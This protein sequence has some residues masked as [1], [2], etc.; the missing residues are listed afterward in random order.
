MKHE[1]AEVQRAN[2]RI[3]D[4]L[5]NLL[6]I[7]QEIVKSPFDLP[8][9]LSR[10]VFA[11]QQALDSDFALLLPYDSQSRSFRVDLFTASGLSDEILK[12]KEKPRSGGVAAQVMS[13][14]TGILVVEDVSDRKRY[15]YVSLEPTSLVPKSG[16]KCFIGARMDAGSEVTGILF[17]DYRKPHTFVAVELTLVRLLANHAAI[18]IQNARLFDRISKSLEEKVKELEELQSRQLAAERLN[19]LAEIA[20]NFAHRIGNDIGTIPVCVQETRQALMVE[21]CD[22]RTADYYLSR[23]EYDAKNFLHTAELLRMPFIDSEVGEVDI[24]RAI[25]E[26]VSQ[27]IVPRDIVVNF[28]LAESLPTIRC[29]LVQFVNVLK[30]LIEN[31]FE[32]MP[33]GGSL[34]IHTRV[35]QLELGSRQVMLEFADT[36]QG[37]P[38]SQ[39]PRIFELFYSTKK[40][41]GM[42]V[43]L[44]ICK[45]FVQRLGGDV[46]VESTAG[47]GTLFR[48]TLPASTT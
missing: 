14:P 31:A 7:T 39:L 27:M 38:T 11:A 37:I 18:A 36:G 8:S 24:N 45:A 1:P 29:D 33:N 25:Y 15:P 12:A 44:W 47:V 20:A 35:E 23:I 16:A 19:M 22:L 41:S 21:P 2:S 34:S 32:A 43:G 48:I 4:D 26:A 9:V 17:V 40:G 3:D 42:G 10:I 6:A 46:Q 30:G 13:S 28:D 5:T